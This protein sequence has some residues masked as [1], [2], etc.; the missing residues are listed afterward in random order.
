MLPL[1]NQQDREGIY[2]H[3]SV[4]EFELFTAENLNVI[5]DIISIRPEGVDGFCFVIWSCVEHGKCYKL[6]VPFTSLT[7]KSPN[8]ETVCIDVQTVLKEMAGQM[9]THLAIH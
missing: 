1:N 9:K 3:T 6:Y 2:L 5:A 8:L 4:S 7:D